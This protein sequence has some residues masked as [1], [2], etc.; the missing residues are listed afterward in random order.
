MW[1]VSWRDR[2]GLVRQY[3]RAVLLLV[4]I[5]TCAVTAAGTAIMTDAVLHLPAIERGAAAMATTAAV[6]AVISL[7]HLM[8]VARPLRMRD[9][10]AGGVIGAVAVTTLLNVATTLL[11]AMVTRAGFTYGSFATVAGLFALLYLI[12]QILVVGVEVSTVIES[13]LSPRGLTTAV[14]TENDRRALTLQAHQQERIAG[15]S[16]TTTFATDAADASVDHR[17]G[18]RAARPQHHGDLQ[19]AHEDEPRAG[20]VDERDQ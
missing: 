16:I 1:G 11:P 5:V 15:Q 14:V 17:H 13:R 8:L 6:F 20:E 4:V 9:V 18:Q 10:W 19:Q 3:A 12:S 2:F 7:A